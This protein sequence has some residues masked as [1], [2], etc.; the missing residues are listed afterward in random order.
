MILLLGLESGISKHTLAIFQ[1]SLKK[2]S[3][4]KDAVGLVRGVGDLI[5]ISAEE[6][7]WFEL[8]GS[9]SNNTSFTRSYKR[10]FLHTSG[11][12]PK[13]RSNTLNKWISKISTYQ[14]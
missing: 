10:V 7:D 5:F 9:S 11:Q 1:R 14:I 13:S 4:D 2:L 3:N 12:T 8:V 6:E